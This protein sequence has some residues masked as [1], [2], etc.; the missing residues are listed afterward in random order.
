MSWRDELP[1]DLKESP[2][3]KDV[4]DIGSLAKQFVDL[5][6]HLG[7]SIRVPSK[8]AGAEDRKSFYDKIIKHAPDLMVRPDVSTPEAK[9]ALMTMLG[10]PGD[11]KDYELPEGSTVGE[12]LIGII[13]KSAHQAG[14]SKEQFKGIVAS[15]NELSVAEQK[16]VKQAL[17]DA[18]STIDKEW[19]LKKD[20]NMKLASTIAA[21]TGA[22]KALVE[23]INKGEA[24]IETLNWLLGL[25]A[26]FPSE[27][28]QI[29]NQEGGGSGK[30]TPAEAKSRI[31]EIRANKEHP[32]WKTSHPDHDEAVKD[33]LELHRQA[34][35][36]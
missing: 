34:N 14:L 8:E 25:A 5:Q 9:D 22:P 11:G 6:A 16:K 18:H 23:A 29:I 32:V 2:S 13:R 10:R 26:R 15:I 33:W 31:N 30:M 35:P 20:H 27:E 12:E 1:D 3:L 17:L 21:V 24:G 28:M 36:S 19:G 4:Q 7:N